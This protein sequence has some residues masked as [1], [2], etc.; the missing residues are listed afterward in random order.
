MGLKAAYLI[1]YKNA[2]CCGGYVYV[3]S[4]MLP[5]VIGSGASLSPLEALSQVYAV[6]NL[7]LAL[8]IVESTTLMEI[9]HAK[10]KIPG[11]CT[12]DPIIYYP[13]T[14]VFVIVSGSCFEDSSPWKSQDLNT[15]KD[16]IFIELMMSS[17][18]LLALTQQ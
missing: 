16:H 14:I 15:E 6:L 11:C 13:Q 4:L 8:N 3:L 5:S 2:A 1:A 9:V 12:A 10:V 18:F 17:N 7:A